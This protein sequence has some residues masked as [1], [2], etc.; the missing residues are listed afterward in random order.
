MAN[1]AYL[2]SAER[3]DAWEHPEEGYNYSRWVIP[4]AWFFFYRVAE[5]TWIDVTFDGMLWWKEARLSAEKDT[6]AKVFAGRRAL[7]SALIGSEIGD[8]EINKFLEVNRSRP[9][10]Y[11]I[12][13]PGE[14]I[15]DEEDAPFFDRLF[16]MVEKGQTEGLTALD[17]DGSAIGGLR[18]S[19]DSYLSGVFGYWCGR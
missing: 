1:L 12:M 8:Q 13:N 16:E 14:V 11:L 19:R 17:H 15:G 10:R 9:G 4:L 18:G 6:A 5:I 7:L 3:P 2:Y